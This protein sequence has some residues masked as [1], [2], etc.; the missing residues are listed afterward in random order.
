MN[1]TQ[2]QTSSLIRRAS[3]ALK[4][5][6]RGV[7]ATTTSRA[8]VIQMGL[9]PMVRM[10]DV[11]ALTGLGASMIYQMMHDGT[12]PTGI[13]LT[14]NGRARG[15]RLSTISAW[16]AERERDGIG[17]RSKGAVT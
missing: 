11:E 13:A 8:A 3:S 10:N 4:P 14:P 1:D 5:R 9:D 12:F 2:I 6:R 15:W 17:A 7:L 16:L